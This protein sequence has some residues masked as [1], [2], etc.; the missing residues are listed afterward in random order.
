[1]IRS[2]EA[3][4]RHLWRHASLSILV[5]VCALAAVGCGEQERA[6]GG[7]AKFEIDKTYERGP[8]SFAVR[9]SRGEVTIADR[10]Q[11]VL[12][13]KAPEGYDV[14]L[15]KFGDKLEQF[16][17]VDYRSPQPR[18]VA[19]GMLLHQRAYELEP[20]LSGE[21]RIP[22]MKVLF[23]KKGEKP[24]RK[25][26]IESEELTIKVKSLLPAQK[27]KL[28]IRDICPPVAL[29]RPGGG[30]LYAGIGLA[31]LVCSGL[32][33]L[34]VWR[35]RRRRR[36][37]WV[38]RVWAHELAY[39]ALAELLADE[40]LEKGEIK[41]F[42]LRLSTIL[43]HYIEDRFGLH[44]PER[45]TEEFLSELSRTDLLD[46]RHKEWLEQFLAHCDLVKFAEYPPTD[47]EIQTAF[48]V[49]K[50]FI[51]ETE[52]EAAE[53]AAMTSATA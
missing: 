10:L 27:A 39:R 49:C 34:V 53:Q 44:A 6:S 16:G 42:Y 19:K 4:M 31:V 52:T 3:A 15:P 24:P 33:G 40:L 26:E 13:V 14:E 30:P 45:T 1:M 28:D 48:D 21:Y 17:I 36:K 29:P 20:F 12:E 8:A 22:P 46:P 37:E 9:A 11:M 38:A 5:G 47:A 41:A 43:R 18:L 50:Q 35:S 2:R 7:P 25:H 23:W 32:V 51:M